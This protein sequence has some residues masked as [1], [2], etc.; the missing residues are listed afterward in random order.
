ME[1][2]V[3]IGD[4]YNA[5]TQTCQTSYLI[6]DADSRNLIQSGK[7]GLKASKQS[8]PLLSI[9]RAVQALAYLREIKKATIYTDSS[10]ALNAL[11]GHSDNKESKRLAADIKRRIKSLP[12]D[13]QI[14][15]CCSGDVRI[16]NEYASTVDTLPGTRMIPA[17][18]DLLQQLDY[19]CDW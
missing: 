16:P 17:D 13:V 10:F 14:R 6:L 5:F 1:V 12:I 4:S 3:Y 11:K 7:C 2:D 19:I 8:L 9:K 15:H 18:Y